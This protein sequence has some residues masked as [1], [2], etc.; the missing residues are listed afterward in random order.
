MGNIKQRQKLFHFTKVELWQHVPEQART[1]C[2]GLVE[3][4][5]EKVFQSEEL[6]RSEHERE[7]P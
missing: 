2:Q 7:D 1:I 3:Q 5:L 4:L 6:E